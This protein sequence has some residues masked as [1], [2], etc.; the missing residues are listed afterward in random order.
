MKIGRGFGMPDWITGLIGICPEC[1]DKDALIIE[2]RDVKGKYY[3]CMSC[4]QEFERL[5]RVN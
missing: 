5:E 2:L 4:Y 1:H 3:H